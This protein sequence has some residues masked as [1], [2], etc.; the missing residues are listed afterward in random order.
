MTKLSISQAIIEKPKQLSRQQELKKKAELR[1]KMGPSTLREDI[2][3]SFVK[4]NENG[5]K[6]G[7]VELGDIWNELKGEYPKKNIRETLLKM[8]RERIIDLQTASDPKA[9][10]KTDLGFYIQADQSFADYDPY[11]SAFKSGRRGY[12]NYVVWRRN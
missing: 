12:I 9:I 5:D 2:K 4:I 10:R 3:K 8:E 6:S 1:S 11:P 7:T